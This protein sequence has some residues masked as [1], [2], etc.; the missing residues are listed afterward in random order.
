MES[1]AS[2]KKA[3]V[4]AGRQ[5]DFGHAFRADDAAISAVTEE[6]NAQASAGSF[7]GPKKKVRFREPFCPSP[8]LY[9][10]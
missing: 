6:N 9:V 5:D 8:L 10:M 7:S 3:P 1:T 2:R 4:A